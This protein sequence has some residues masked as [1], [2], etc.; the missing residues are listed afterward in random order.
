MKEIDRRLRPLKGEMRTSVG[1]I[2]PASAKLVKVAR[3]LITL[4]ADTSKR[5]SANELKIAYI[6]TTRA[7]LPQL[8]TKAILPTNREMKAKKR[9]TG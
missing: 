6:R 2:L 1:I 7:L 8:P 3:G 9:T 5:E 4:R